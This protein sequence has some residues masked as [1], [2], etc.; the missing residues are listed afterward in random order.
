MGTTY[1]ANPFKE[2]GDPTV[3]AEARASRPRS[4]HAHAAAPVTVAHVASFDPTCPF[5]PGNEA[6]TP[7]EVAAFRPTGSAPDTPGWSVRVVPNKYPALTA[8]KDGRAPTDEVVFSPDDVYDDCEAV[9][10]HEVAIHSPDHEGRLS[11]LG[12]DNL[13]ATMRMWQE[14]LDVHRDAGWPATTLVV[15]EG[16]EAGASLA[17]PHA[18]LFATALVPPV[19]DREL[20]VQGH[21]HETLGRHLLDD[22]V[23]AEAGADR[24]VASAGPLIAWTPYWAE[25]PYEVWIAGRERDSVS[26]RFAD[27]PHVD[28][29][30]DVVGRLT[31][32]IAQVAADP[33]LNVIVRDVPHNGSHGSR[34]HVRIIPR[35]SIAAGFE[36]A[37]GM[38]IVTVTPETA[39][40]ALRSVV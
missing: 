13:G 1:R 7:P 19:L 27:S 36:I 28:A 6:D 29:L 2:D 16:R 10:L 35:T 4:A 21:Y 15:N 12:P 22:V 33:A 24:H 38:R 14:R 30:A 3:V 37:T 40:A 18:Q 39:A 17:H 9:G 20:W 34:W 31:R 26:G 23:T 32:A 8:P 5:C 11:T 25:V